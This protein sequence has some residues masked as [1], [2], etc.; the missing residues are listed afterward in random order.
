MVTFKALFCV[1]EFELLIHE[2]ESMQMKLQ[3]QED[4]FRLQNE[5]LMNE[6]GK[7]LSEI[8]F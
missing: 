3:S 6:L 2:N 4:D 1:Q 5:A 7:V 8:Y